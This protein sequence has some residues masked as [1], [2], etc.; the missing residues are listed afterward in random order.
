MWLSGRMQSRS[1]ALGLSPIL[2]KKK[3]V[4]SISVTVYI[5]LGVESNPLWSSKMT[6]H[7]QHHHSPCHPGSKCQSSLMCLSPLPPM[8]SHTLVLCVFLGTLSYSCSTLPPHRHPSFTPWLEAQAPGDREHMLAMG[9]LLCGV[10][11]RGGAVWEVRCLGT[12]PST[13]LFP[14][15]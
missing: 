13:C 4:L 14:P 11:K 9:S 5:W 1:K 15:V 8:W 10:V 12:W 6:S 2:K 7:T 3:K